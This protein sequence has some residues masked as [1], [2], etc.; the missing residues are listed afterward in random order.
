MTFRSRTF[1]GLLPEE[2]FHRLVGAIP[3]AFREKNLAGVVWVELAEDES[4]EEFLKL[5]RSEDVTG[6]ER[7]IYVE[8]AK[9]RMFDVLAEQMGASPD[10]RC[11]GD[12]R[13]MAGLLS[14]RR[15]PEGKSRDAKLLMIRHHAYCD[16]QVVLT[17]WPA[18]RQLYAGAA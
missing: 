16:C 6:R 14:A 17:A 3:A 1:N 13:E 8:L 9:A 4:L 7:E 2:R 15:F 5:P 11:S 10:K 12:F 18:L